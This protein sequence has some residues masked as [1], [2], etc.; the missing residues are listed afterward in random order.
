MLLNREAHLFLVCLMC[1]AFYKYTYIHIYVYC[2][3]MHMS[4]YVST[5]AN[6]LN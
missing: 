3:Y 1:C 4:V 6:Y 2:V 5:F